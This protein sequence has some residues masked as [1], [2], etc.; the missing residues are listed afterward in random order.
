MCLYRMWCVLN[1]FISKLALQLWQVVSSNPKQRQKMQITV[2]FACLVISAVSAAQND[3]TVACYMDASMQHMFL[4]ID[5]FWCT[6]IIYSIAYIGDDFSLKT[7]SLDIDPFNSMLKMLK[8]RNPALKTLLGVGVNQSRLELLSQQQITLDN[9]INST[10]E[11][12]KKNNYDGVDLT[13]LEN[14]TNA[15]LMNTKT[16]TSFSKELRG[17]IDQ[18]ADKTLL[19][20]VSLLEHNDHIS[21]HIDKT[22]SQYIDFICLLLLSPNNEGTQTDSTV[23]YWLDKVDPKK[24]ILALPAIVQQPRKGQNSSQS[25]IMGMNPEGTVEQ[26]NGPVLIIAKQVCQAIKSGQK[27]LKTLTKLDSVR[28]H[29]LDV[30][31]L[32]KG[33]GGVGVVMLDIDIFLNL[34]CLNCTQSEKAILELNVRFLAR[35]SGLPFL[36]LIPLPPR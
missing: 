30:S 19:V 5:P 28:S 25:R 10:L 31:W 16:L 27:E 23:S 9:F 7:L 12:L 26:M 33:L 14:D 20:S 3:S 11:Y 29:G 13:W 4:S 22:W 24:L 15:T 17:W 34:I 32:Q 35:V 36:T 21:S 6:H 8:D 1:Y 2:V 18:T